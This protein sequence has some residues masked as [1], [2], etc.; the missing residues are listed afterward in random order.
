MILFDCL[1]H[2]VSDTKEGEL[3]KFARRIGLDRGWYQTKKGLHPH[4]DFTSDRMREKARKAGA[5]QV[6]PQDLVRRA[7]WAAA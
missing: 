3:H 5:I 1:G 2:M 6:T 7:W 4:Y